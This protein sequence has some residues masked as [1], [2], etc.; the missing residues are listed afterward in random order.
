MEARQ[1]SLE[2][3]VVGVHVLHM[4]GALD[5]IADSLSG[6][7]I[8]SLVCDTMGTGE[9]G[10]GGVGVGDQQRLRIEF[11]QKVPDQLGTFRAPRPVTASMVWPLRSRAT[12][13]QSR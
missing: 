4:D 3:P 13:M 10:I 1:P 8:D 9:G 2:A 11:R 12:R 6:A 7:E 5:A